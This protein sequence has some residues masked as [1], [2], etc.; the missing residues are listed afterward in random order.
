MEEQ[1]KELA[2]QYKAF[3]S[4]SHSDNQGEGRKWA[5][6]L[7]HAL[8]TYEIPQDLIGKKN[9]AGKEIPRQIYPVFQD[10]K[11]LSASSSLSGS[12]TDALDRSEYL[13]YLSS[14]KSARSTYVRD[15]LR[16]FKQSGKSQQ[17]MALI[18][19]GEPEYGDTITEAQCFPD[20][21]RYHV[22]GDGQVDKS[23]PEEVLAADVRI[24]HTQEEGFTSPEAY[25]MHLHEQGLSHQEIKSRVDEYKQR[26]D[27]ALLKIISG[28]LGVPLGELTKRD[29]AYQLEKIKQ[30]NRNIKRIAAVIGVL[31]I[32]A[33]IAGIFAWNQRNS[34]IRNLAKSLYASGINKLTESEY[35]DGAAYIAEATRRGDDD[36]KLFAHSML[37]VQD[38]MTLMPNINVGNLRFSPN[39]RW[40]VGWAS[41]GDFTQV[42]QVWDAINRK[43]I[44]QLGQVK[45]KQARYPSF[46]QSNRAYVTTVDNSI[47]RY[48]IDKDKLE[49]IRANPDSTFL[50][51]SAVSG[52]GKLVL[53]KQMEKLYL[54]NTETKQE[55][56]LHTL[57]GY[58]LETSYFSPKLD[59]LVIGIAHKEKNEWL[60]FDI[61]TT[62]PTLKLRKETPYTSKPPAFSPD[63]K[64]V[65]LYGNF[66][67]NYYNLATG[68]EWTNTQVNTAKYV[69]F[70]TNGQLHAGNNEQIA[71]L[72]L[73]TGAV[74]KSTALPGNVFFISPLTKMLEQDDMA[75]QYN[76]PNWNQQL[77]SSDNQTFI[78]NVKAA[79]LQ[80]A[81][82]FEPNEL[83]VAVP[84][85][86]ENVAYTIYK[87]SKSIDELNLENGTKTKNIIT[88][89]ENIATII[90]LHKTKNLLVKGKSGKT[91]FYDLN[92]RKPIGK[93]ID[94]QPKLYIFKVDENEVASR[95]GKN[96]FAAWD[97]ATGKQIFKYEEKAE[98]PGFTISPDFTQAIL[99]GPSSWKI[100]DP[101]SGKVL[102]EEK[103]TLSSGRYSNTGKYLVLT[104]NNGSTKLLNSTDYK[105]VFSLKTIEFPFMMFNN[106]DDVLAI[107]DDADHMRLWNIE[108]GKP[109]GQRIRVSKYSKYFHFSDDD[110]QIFVQDDGNGLQFVT[111][112]VDAR[113]GNIL[114]MPFMNQKF[115]NI[116][117]L[118]GDKKLMTIE[119]LVLGKTVN[120]WEVPGQV[121]IA[122][123]QVARDLEKFYGKKYDNASGAIFPFVDTTGNYS[124]WYFDDP[125]LRSIS[126]SSK[127][128]I[129]E[130]L[131]QNYP[132][133]TDANLQ[134]LAVTHIYHPLARAMVANHYSSK[135]E[136]QYIG[137]RLVEVTEKQL[138]L[139]KNNELKAEVEKLLNEAK[140]KLK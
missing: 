22:D 26:L 39:G 72:N 73:T 62:T 113:T 8:E 49:T 71:Q 10:E 21:L 69:G 85:I 37:A 105:E 55:Q 96:S 118:P 108:T 74:A 70:T 6:W 121:D 137:Q 134:L 3:I 50:T 94:A 109:F 24:P 66:G 20:E 122:N 110:K 51:I 63:G 77:V 120:T 87:D 114:T 65:A 59:L 1:N 68:Q 52:D 133:K 124:T 91:Y 19:K 123:E 107:S 92:S 38:D 131:R 31:G 12:L 86:T 14:P 103:G 135:P 13:I 81:Q 44:K 100:V 129:L 36:A 89:P 116:F 140:S 43:P 82:Y 32:L 58:P 126:P 56:Q 97:I 35:G 64:Q 67:I 98:I 18:L 90:V 42:L 93:A 84:G 128:S 80:L 30:K 5:D 4:Y 33:I 9:T 29:Q 75:L 83:I 95:T 136:M 106:A 127:T 78:D 34:A 139:I 99:V 61:T 25:R 54:L 28:I 101:H 45:T 102:K 57:S 130:I 138:L 2:K 16:Y 76:S 117:V 48:D 47:V 46:D 41:S 40:L 79:P 115:S 23:K 119:E 112:I 27:L 132:I 125:F 53:F 104:D 88:A 7:H 111:K 60:F 17:I 11:E 15:E